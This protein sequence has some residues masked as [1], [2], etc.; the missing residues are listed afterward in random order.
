MRKILITGGAGF[1]GRRFCKRFLDAGDE[2]HCVDPERVFLR[3]EQP[4]PVL[5]RWAPVNDLG[6]LPFVVVLVET[7]LLNARENFFTVQ[8]DEVF[9]D[10]TI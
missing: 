2:V 10:V 5:G 6:V 7:Q 1:V 3:G 8:R 4:V 9:F